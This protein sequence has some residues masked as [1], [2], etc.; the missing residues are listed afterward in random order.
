MIE[1]RDSTSRV[2]GNFQSAFKTHGMHANH[3]PVVLLH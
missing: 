3:E 1:A 2:L